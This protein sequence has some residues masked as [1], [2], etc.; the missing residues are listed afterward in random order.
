MSFPKHWENN[1]P[2]H[3]NN[4]ISRSW[5]AIEWTD[6]E[7]VREKMLAFCKNLRRHPDDCPFVL[8]DLPSEDIPGLEELLM[9][10]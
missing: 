7:V 4:P 8:I 1:P 5:D 3:T 6:K 10:E 9:E 2:I